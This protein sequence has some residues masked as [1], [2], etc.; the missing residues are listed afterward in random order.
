MKTS[1]LIELRLQRLR[2][3]ARAMHLSLATE[4]TYAGWVRRFITFSAGQSDCMTAPPEDMARRFVEAHASEWAVATQ[5]QFRNALVFYFR[6]V[7]E[8]PLGQLGEWSRAKRP[9]RLPVWLPHAQMLD[10]I[11]HLRGPMRLMA[12]IGYGSGVRS[13]E[14]ARMRV[15]DLDFTAQTITVRGGKGDKD[16]VTFL[17]ASEIPALQAHLDDMRRLHLRDRRDARPGVETGS[18]KF[19]GEDWPWFW[20]W[21]APNESRDP[22]TGIV[23]RHHVHKSTLGKALAV[24][25]KRAGCDRRVTQHSLR[26]S[27][28]TTLLD[29]GIGIHVVSRLLGHVHI[30]TTEIYAHVLPRQAVVQ[31]ESPMDIAPGNVLPVQFSAPT[32]DFRIHRHA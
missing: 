3:V 20:V 14:L 1:E 26:H 19:T 9:V 6:R 11:S 7:L 24:A 22:R 17:P 21:A 2:T 29:R 23:R 12:A 10:L 4:R 28:A 16:R 18:A 27:F 8:R 30:A 13:H 31:A 5:D 32:P 25:V 15:N